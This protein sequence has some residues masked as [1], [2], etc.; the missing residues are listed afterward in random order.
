MNP[1]SPGSLPAACAAG[2]KIPGGLKENR[3]GPAVNVFP[4]NSGRIS[5]KEPSVSRLLLRLSPPVENE[6]F[7][8]GRTEHAGAAAS[9]KTF[10]KIRDLELLYYCISVCYQCLKFPFVRQISVSNCALRKP[11]GVPGPP[12]LAAS[13]PASTAGQPSSRQPGAASG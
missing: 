8:E 1:N 2:C 6:R 12:A 3:L 10:L 9:I 13:P 7:K 4:E 5:Q 11:R